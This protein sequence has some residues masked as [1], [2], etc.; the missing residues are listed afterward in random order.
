[1]DWQEFI[2]GIKEKA[3][4]QAWTAAHNVGAE[5]N[6]VIFKV[7]TG[8][9]YN[10]LPHKPVLPSPKSKLVTVGGSMLDAVGVCKVII[11][12]P[13]TQFSVQKPSTWSKMASTISLVDVY[14]NSWDSSHSMAPLY[15]SPQRP[16]SP[17]AI[18]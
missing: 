6:K 17:P 10:L 3:P 4:S 15:K 14:H 16:P 7:D 9:D 2:L 13:Q 11:K 12:R 5:S 1:M 18:W 8:A